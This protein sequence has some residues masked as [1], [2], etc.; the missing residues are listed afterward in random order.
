MTLET[1]YLVVG[2]GALGM[3]FADA[4][5]PRS[6]AD[7]I[8]VDRH[9]S[10]GGHWNDDYDFVQLHQPSAYYGC[11]STPLGSD[12]LDE[13]GPN[14]GFYE[15]ATG[16]QMRRYY[17]RVLQEKLLPTGRVRFLGLSS[18]LGE[19]SREHVVSSLITGAT[20][21]IRVRKRVV[22]ATYIA[23][24]LPSMH[25]P[26]FSV[27][28]GA[29]LVPPNALVRLDSPGSRFTVIGAGKTAMDTCCWLIDNGVDPDAIR[30][31]RPRDPFTVD[32]TWAQPLKLAGSMAEWLART[33]EAAA[34]A[35][36]AR[37]LVRLLEEREVIRRLDPN[38]EASVYRGATL[39]P[40]ERT[41]LARIS[42]VV[43]LGRVVHLGRD[44]VQLEGG[45]IPARAAEVFVD[46]SAPGLGMPPARP[47]FEQDRITLQRVQA[48][49]D[50][51]S[52]AVI[53]VVESTDRDV[54]EKNTLCP[55]NAFT[56]EV[57]NLGREILV[58]LVARTRW[59][60]EP[61]IR[62]WLS[63][64]RLSPLRGVSRYMSPEMQA[65]LGRLVTS[66]PRAIE[67]LERIYGPVP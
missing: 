58:T 31:I 51:F 10:P 61:D 3:G 13:S 59:L 65:S 21:S 44:Q 27:E 38:A 25:K 53:G 46:C 19:S 9:H 67:N 54:R 56:G 39:S 11:D 22:D 35:D 34:D 43:R 37:D 23:T 18:Y 5:V 64:T 40:L 49:V 42:D 47:V 60:A 55:P 62:D 57:L 12:H 66:T 14:A 63:T 6:D 8:L 45:T 50:P 20:R 41:T 33:Y 28:P 4:M 32:R 15:R 16:R 2:A 7:V 26:S 24:T 29:R 52:A 36:D 1:D 30:W 48:G 17:E